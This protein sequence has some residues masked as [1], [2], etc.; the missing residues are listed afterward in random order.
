LFF[1]FFLFIIC[2]RISYDFL[3]VAKGDG[4][5]EIRS[6]GV[7]SKAFSVGVQGVCLSHCDAGSIQAVWRSNSILKHSNTTSRVQE[8]LVIIYNTRYL[9][10]VAD[11]RLKANKERPSEIASV[12]RQ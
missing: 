7:F 6:T 1:F 8:F 9:N 11:G 4:K 5:G 3:S 10:A 2:P 12:P